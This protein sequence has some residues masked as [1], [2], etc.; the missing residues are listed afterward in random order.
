MAPRNG[1]EEDS[2]RVIAFSYG[3][4]VGRFHDGFGHAAPSHEFVTDAKRISGI[5]IVVRIDDGQWKRVTPSL[6]LLGVAASGLPIPPSEGGKIWTKQR[7]LSGQ[8]VSFRRQ[9]PTCCSNR[10]GSVLS[11]SGIAS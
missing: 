5:L 7:R 9:A 8:L 10:T 6:P 4:G 3:D 2:H 11:S 1:L